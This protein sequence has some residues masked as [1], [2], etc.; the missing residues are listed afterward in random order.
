MASTAATPAQATAGRRRPNGVRRRAGAPS[1]R[2][3]CAS[4]STVS[5]IEAL[6]DAG[7]ATGVTERGSASSAGRS[8]S[9]SLRH[10]L[11]WARWRSKA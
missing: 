6:S 4:R 10:S 5:M 8:S 2:R 3:V 1:V 7:G 11:Q 9:I